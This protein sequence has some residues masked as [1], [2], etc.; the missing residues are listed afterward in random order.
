M[1]SGTNCTAVDRRIASVFVAHDADRSGALDQAEL[2]P[3][4]AKLGVHLT[5]QVR[6][7]AVHSLAPN[8]IQCSS[9][10]HPETTIASLVEHATA[11]A[12]SLAAPVTVPCHRPTRVLTTILV[13]S[14]VVWP[15]AL[16]YET[17][18]KGPR[19]PFNWTN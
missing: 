7:P 3:A 17:L 2:R 15:Q 10:A 5:K 4:L 14:G 18:G 16:S 6:A 1:A 8:P 11:R 13:F 19:V 9:C 12:H